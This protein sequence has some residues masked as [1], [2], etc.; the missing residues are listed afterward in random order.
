MFD[1]YDK[2]GKLIDLITW[3]RLCEDKSYKIIQQEE[4]PN[5][6]WVSTVWLG[7]DYGMHRYDE[8]SLPIIFETMVFSRKEDWSNVEECE[9]YCTLKEAEEGHKKMVEKYNI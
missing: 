7:I 1:F 8:E 3:G 5:N 6:K 9:R 2:E 4:L